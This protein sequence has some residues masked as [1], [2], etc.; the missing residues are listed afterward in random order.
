M[1]DPELRRLIEDIVKQQLN[2][3]LTAKTTSSK[4]KTESISDLFP[5]MPT[6]SDRPVMAPYG[7]A[8]KPPMGTKSV[9]GQHGDFKGNRI[10][11]GHRDEKRPTDL[12]DGE[13]M[14]YSL[15]KYKV[16]CF[17]DKIQIGK[18]GVYETVVAGETLVDFL[19][20]F[21]DA[22]IA[23]THIGNLGYPTSPIN[24]N[25]AAEILKANFL[26]NEKVLGKDGGRF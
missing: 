6:I 15:G 20:Q 14:I 16:K 4:V 17:L 18:D 3:I 25:F 7:V 26:T 24:E 9:V 13:A 5:G 23:H 12:D 8:S 1:I 2:I 22:F 19:T 11:L 10:V 21:I